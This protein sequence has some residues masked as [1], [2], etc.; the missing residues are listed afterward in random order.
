VEWIR[1]NVADKIL[2]KNDMA[3]V[4]WFGSPGLLISEL[5]RVALNRNAMGSRFD[6]WMVIG[7]LG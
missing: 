6:C 7:R 3:K 1:G 2:K 4:L 5:I